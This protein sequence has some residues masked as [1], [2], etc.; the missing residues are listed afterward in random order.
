M[1][2]TVPLRHG[3]GILAWFKWQPLLARRG[4]EQRAFCAGGGR[5]LAKGKHSGVTFEDG[6]RTGSYTNMASRSR[7]E[8]V[9][10]FENMS[11]ESGPSTRAQQNSVPKAHIVV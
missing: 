10:D 2:V 5:V 4:G 9:F 6:E 7:A 8:V 11:Y 3:R 1:S